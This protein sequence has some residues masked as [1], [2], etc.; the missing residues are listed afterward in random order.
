MN[1][2][3]SQQDFETVNEYLDCNR[4]KLLDIKINDAL[5]DDAPIIDRYPKEMYYRIFAARY[6]PQDMDKILY[7]DPDLIVRKDLQ[8]LYD[9]NID[10]YYFAAATHVP[11]PLRK[12]NQIRLQALEE[13]PYINSGV[14]LMNL[15]M[16]RQHQNYN[17]V[18]EYIKK[19]KN[20]LFLPDQDV[21]SA[22][23]A[24]KILSIDPYVYNMTERLLHVPLLAGKK[25]DYD[26]VENNTAIIHFC[27]R[28]KPWNDMYMGAL[29]QLYHSVI[30][31]P[32]PN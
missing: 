15:K 6:L 21:I 5:L 28:N 25:V 2:S 13:G 7:L 24:S 19:N 30:R 8:S 16:L 4:F 1:S 31:S 20:L 11:E 22:I 12:L 14:M 9:L 10:N 23:Y 29:D 17:Q 32:K 26:W 18:F 27:G 3:L